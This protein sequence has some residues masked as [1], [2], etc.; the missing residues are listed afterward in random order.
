M[1][2]YSEPLANKLAVTGF[3]L[4]QT[5]RTRSWEILL[6]TDEAFS[7]N[8]GRLDARS[9]N[10][11]YGNHLQLSLKDFTR[12]GT[13]KQDY[14]QWQARIMT[15]VDVNTRPQVKLAIEQ[16]YET[17]NRFKSGISSFPKN[18]K[19]YSEENQNSMI[20]PF[21][22]AAIPLDITTSALE[23]NL[24]AYNPIVNALVDKKITISDIADYQHLPVEWVRKL[25]Y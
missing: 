15:N 18:F 11:S 5:P 13:F 1:P 24:S 8:F 22:L 4:K 10:S 17:L 20:L 21:H 19:R 6:K 14:M 7:F 12:G 16:Q 3:H 23:K 25:L 9:G 2:S